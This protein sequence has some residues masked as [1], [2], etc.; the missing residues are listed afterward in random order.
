MGDLDSGVLDYDFLRVD[1]HY[2]P[3]CAE[4][5]ITDNPVKLNITDLR[6]KDRGRPLL[7]DDQSD[8]AI[9][10]GGRLGDGERNRIREKL[11]VARAADLYPQAARSPDDIGCHPGLDFTLAHECRRKVTAIEVN[12]CV[13]WNLGAIERQVEISR[14]CNHTRRIDRVERDRRWNWCGGRRC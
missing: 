1:T 14:P 4:F 7:F 10:R 9:R 3:I 8:V 6:F 11:G 13:L 12:L 5:L 2:S